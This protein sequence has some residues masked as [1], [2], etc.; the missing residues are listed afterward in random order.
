MIIDK[1]SETTSRHHVVLVGDFLDF[2]TQLLAL[3][4]VADHTQDV[5]FSVRVLLRLQA[6]GD[7]WRWVH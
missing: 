1:L 3:Q 6:G 7:R 2:V 4:E 5:V